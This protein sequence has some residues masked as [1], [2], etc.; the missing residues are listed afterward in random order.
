VTQ[1]GCRLLFLPAYSRYFSPIEEDFSK[2]KA[3]VRRYR[4]Q[5]LPDLTE[6]S[7]RGL[8]KITAIEANGWFAHV[9]FSV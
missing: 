8:N 7:E 6:A 2:L 9:G 1:A 3:F 4:R 5:P